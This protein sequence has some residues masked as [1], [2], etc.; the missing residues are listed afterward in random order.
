MSKIATPYDADIADFKKLGSK[1]NPGFLKALQL[2]CEGY[3]RGFAA[4]NAAHSCQDTGCP[5]YLRGREAEA[6]E[7]SVSGRQT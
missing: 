7:P 3:L 4:G 1:A 6:E 5:C 2:R